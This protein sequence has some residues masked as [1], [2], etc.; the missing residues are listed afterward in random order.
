MDLAG[1]NIRNLANGIHILQHL[2]RYKKSQ[3]YSREELLDVQTIQLKHILWNAV[4]NVPYYRSLKLSIDFENF[5]LN[6]LQKFPIMSKQIMQQQY[7]NFISD[8]FNFNKL[9][10]KSTSGSSGM[11]FKVA[12]SYYSD[13]IEYCM[14]LRAWS[15]SNT[16]DY[17]FRDPCVVLRSFSP[18]PGEQLFKQDKILNY[19]F[20]SPYDINQKNL[21][22]YLS[23]FKQSKAKLLRGYPSSIYILTLLLKENNI[24]IP[25]IK[26]LFTSS[27]NLL[28]QYK[29]VI[30]DYWQLPIIDWYGQN[31]RTVTVQKCSHGNYHN[32]DEYGIVELDAKNQIIATSLKND[33]MPLIRYATNDIA[34]PSNTTTCTCGR[35]LSIPFAGIDGRADDLLMKDDGTVMATV[36]I[37]NAM[38]KFQDVKQFKIIQ[39]EDKSIQLFLSENKSLSKEYIYKIEQELYQRLGNVSLKTDIVQEIERDRVTGKIKSIES[40]IKF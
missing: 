30:E 38:E 31:E 18:K 16:Y 26:T 10:F 21:D 40:R 15:M 36:N 29:K 37:Y 23:V 7:K 19:W 12:K 6:E 9:Q 27:E 5:S 11:P 35:G 17:T 34:I 1:I 24:H 28:P 32:N 4:N 33:V 14:M 25:Q 39:A 20:L 8:K 22:I 3:F 13:A 2:K